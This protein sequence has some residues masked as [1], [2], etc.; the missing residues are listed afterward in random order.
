MP[1][2]LIKR[3]IIK[4]FAKIVQPLT[5]LLKNDVEFIFDEKCKQAFQLLKDRRI[6]APVIRTPDWNYPFEVMYEVNDF[7]VGAVLGQ[8]IEG[9][10]YVI[11]YASKT[12]NQAQ[13]NYDMTEMVM[14]IVY[15]FEK[16]RSYLL[17]SKVI[18]YSGQER[19]KAQIVPLGVI[20][21][22]VP[23]GRKG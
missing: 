4:D 17:G 9:K 2:R 3:R 7:T 11:F 20:V 22:R 8:R 18:V 12:L 13:K 15:S 23:L 14:L 10:C 21:A 16:F 5:H 1:R 6:S 19:V